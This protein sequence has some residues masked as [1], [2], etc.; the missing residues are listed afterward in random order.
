MTELQEQYENIMHAVAAEDV[1]GVLGEGETAEI[2]KRLERSYHNLAK[3]VHPDL[4]ADNLDSR[5]MAEEAFKQLG[6]FYEE[7][8]KRVINGIY[9]RKFD[10]RQAEFSIRVGEREYHLE[11]ELAR[12]EIATIYRGYCLGSD[13]FAGRI[14]AKIVNDPADNDLAQNELK[15]LRI[16]KSEPSKQSKHLP[17]LIDQFRSGDNRQGLILREIDGYNLEQVKKRYPNGI[18]PKHLVWMLNR[19]LSASGLV[20]SKGIVHGNIEPAHIMIRPRDHNAWLIDWSY[21]ATK[22]FQTGDG[23]K[24]VNEV[25]SAPEVAKRQTPTPSADLYSLGK[26]MIYI[27]GGDEVTNKLPKAVPEPL[28]RFIKYFVFKSPVQRPADAWEMHGELI[29]LIETLWGPRKFIEFEM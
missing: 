21:A 6:N 22:P 2:L 10:R 19:L 5:E 15:V 9:G 16:F 3:T 14:V 27:L 18:D 29:N 26:C 23:F 25:Y 1:F 4:Y 8:K 20:H 28:G 11:E 13:E 17:V 7:A 24:A 12:G